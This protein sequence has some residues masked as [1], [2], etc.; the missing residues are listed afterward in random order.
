[1]GLLVCMTIMIIQFIDHKKVSSYW[2]V[3]TDHL[4]PL[5]NDAFSLPTAIM[6]LSPSLKVNLCMSKKGGVH[7]SQCKILL[8]LEKILNLS[9]ASCGGIPTIVIKVQ[10]MIHCYFW[11]TPRSLTPPSCQHSSGRELMWTSCGWESVR[12]LHLLWVCRI[13]LTR[14]FVVASPHFPCTNNQ[15]HCIVNHKKLWT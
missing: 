15:R 4:L 10:D 7:K 13:H 6:D 5:A 12:S 8:E 9:K 2:S 1:M 14:D 11:A 3:H